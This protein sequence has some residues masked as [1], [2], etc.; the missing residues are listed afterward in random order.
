MLN[1]VS[2]GRGRGLG[3][4]YKSLIPRL[5]PSFF[6]SAHAKGNGG[7]ETVHVPEEGGHDH[8]HSLKNLI[9]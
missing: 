4:C 1:L 9:Y 2:R 3:A 7:G 8:V 6:F 5:S